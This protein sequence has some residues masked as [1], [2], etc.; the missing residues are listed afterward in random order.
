LPD[1]WRAVTVSVS[2]VLDETTLEHLMTGRL[3]DH[4]EELAR[5]GSVEPL[6]LS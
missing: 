2:S 1:V 3:P 5:T 4:V 6:A